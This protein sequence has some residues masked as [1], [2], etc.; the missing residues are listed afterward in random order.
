VLGERVWPVSPLDL[1]AARQLF[2]D[3]AQA[4]SPGYDPQVADA[5]AIQR[6]VDEVDR[7]PLAIELAAARVGAMGWRSWPRS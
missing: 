5:A 2:V 3:R 1:T 6:V 4:V 7:L